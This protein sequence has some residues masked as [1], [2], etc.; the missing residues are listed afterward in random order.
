MPIS[1]IVPIYNVAQYLRACINS[2]VNQTYR[3]I[4][5]I[6]IDD[7][8][9]DDSGSICE[10][11]KK[12]DERIVVIHQNN[13]GLSAARNAGIKLSTGEY[14]T[15]IDS[16]DYISPDYIKKLHSCFADNTIDIVV[17]DLKK[18]PEKVELSDINLQ[19]EKDT[20]SVRLSNCQAIEE[21]YK[22]SY[23]GIDF[24][25]FA[26]LYRK[27]L[28]EI[29]EIEFPVGKIHEDA[30]TTYKLFYASKEIVYVDIPMY[31]Y[32]IRGGSITTS[33]FSLKRLDKI[34]ATKEECD[35]FVK[36]KQYRLL[37]FA[38]CDHL[39]EIKL[40]IYN[41]NKFNHQYDEHIK[42]LAAQL[43]DD[44]GYY[45]Q[46]TRISTKKKIYYRLLAS[47]PIGLLANI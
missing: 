22:S 34:V 44:L 25:S 28:F 30:F 1:I 40:A 31:F 18:V 26:K 36:E 21:V 20:N 33:D 45:S 46:Y 32:R 7:G 6:L 38:L 19:V 4:E 16:D 15:F 27:A 39:H 14:I 29:N 17:C 37:Q 9:T 2:I 5:I 41:L 8:S 42:L 43:K 47:L 35:F 23:H 12:I 11:Y 10:E 3:D 24:V 13:A